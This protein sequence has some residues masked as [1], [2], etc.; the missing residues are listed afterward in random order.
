M[1]KQNGF[2]LIELLVVISML[3][4]LATFVFVN[5]RSAASDQLLA[6]AVIEIQT[7]L[8]FAQSNATTGTV[9]VGPGGNSWTVKFRQ[10]DKSKLDLT[11]GTTDTPRQSLTLQDVEVSSFQCNPADTTICP[12]VD[13]VFTP[14]LS[15]NYSPLYGNINFSSGAVCS[16][17]AS[18]IM[19]TLRNIKNNNKKC[20]TISKG[21][22][23]NVK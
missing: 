21:G 3:G 1:P 11:C 12:P 23:V 5:Y 6:K 9:C 17:T 16:N 15:V 10:N 8:K 2:T 22:A 14:P 20:F 4:I 13:D 19:V 7:L 18:T